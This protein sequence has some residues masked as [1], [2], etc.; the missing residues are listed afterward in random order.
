MMMLGLY[1]A[2]PSS[3]GNLLLDAS[4]FISAAT[5]STNEHGFEALPATVQRRLID[6]FRFY[7]QSLI[8]VGMIWNGAIV[9]EGR[10]EDPA[11]ASNAQ[12]SSLKIQALGAWRALM[13]DRYTALWSTTSLADWKPMPPEITATTIP[14]REPSRFQID[15]NNRLYIAPQLGATYANAGANNICGAVYYQ[16]P[17]QG[18]R[19]PGVVGGIQFDYEM[20]FPVNWQAVLSIHNSAGTQIGSIWALNATAVLQTGSVHLDALGGNPV[21]FVFYIRF[22]AAAAAHPNENGVNYLKI[23]N[24][25]ITTNDT[26]RV[27]TTWSAPA[28]P[29]TGAQTITPASMTGIYVGQ[30]LFIRQ[31]HATLAESVIVTA[32]TTTTF[33]AT[34]AKNHSAGE[35]IHAHQIYADE[36]AGHIASQISTLNS[37]QLSSSAALLQSPGLDLTDEIYEDAVPADVLTHLVELGDNQ[38]PPRQWEAGV[39]ENRMLYFRPRGDVARAWHVDA[40]NLEIARSLEDVSN[41]VYAVYQDA[42][43][44]ALR[45][46]NGTD[47][48]SIAR[49]G[50]TR[51]SSIN[52]NT[53]S[54][55]QASVQRDADLADHKDPLPRATV[56]FE[57]V[58]DAAGGHWP[59]WMVRSGD[60]I[61][62]RN[63][64]PTTSTAIDRVRTFRISHT[65]YDL[66]ARTLEVELEVPPPRLATLLAQQAE[67]IKR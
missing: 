25:R 49:Y 7:D 15:T 23:T 21:L 43:G 16:L 24:L 28:G 2:P 29:V 67:G 58:Y 47:T 56:A 52:A 51:R 44:R 66:M 36:I 33:T 59:L 26:H 39:Y 34:F 60:T 38:V 6:S 35:T 40:T 45:T 17:D 18:T 14:T 46:A 32:I 55:T 10:L 20:L 57:A 48:T 27:N 8:Y 22:N 41:S 31:G 53:T 19:N 1:D 42:A 4:P 13:D 63:L 50:I 5:F 3:G 12:S 30:R 9:W 37:S 65:A 11:V 54:S 62:I 64:P 61:T